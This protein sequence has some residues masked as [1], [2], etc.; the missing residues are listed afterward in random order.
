V[1]A[2]RVGPRD[3]VAVE[4]D[5]RPWRVLP[6]DVV[7][8]TQLRVG[9]E[10]ERADLRDVR[11]E[12]RRHEALV[13]AGRAL[14]DRDLSRV[15]LDE[16]LE[17]AG[18]PPAARAEALETLERVGAVDDARTA[19]ARAAALADRGYGDAA[20]RADL[21][22][23][24]LPVDDAVAA[25]EDERVRAQRLVAA[26]GGGAKTVR[27]LAARGFGEDACEAAVEAALANGSGESYD[28]GASTD[29]LPA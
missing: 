3:G 6:A 20:I 5:G 25:L 13:A 23:R 15:A 10:L 24:G 9:R 1:T 27:F 16:R 4:L 11:R 18:A 22:R 2:L 7:V 29:V 14:R 26:R 17:R 12:L 21:E 28:S 8:R 19:A